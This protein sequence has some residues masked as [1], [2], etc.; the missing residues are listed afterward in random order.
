[1]VAAGFLGL[2]GARRCTVSDRDGG[3]HFAMMRTLFLQAPSFDGFDGGAGARYQMSREVRSF[4]YPTWL[5]QPAALVEGSKL[6]DAPPHRLSFEDVAPEATRRDLVVMHTST[7]SFASDV[8]TAEALKALN[9]DLKIGLI[10]AKV[11]VE[12]EQSLQA[13]SAI[14]F[15]ARNEFDFTIKD[16]AEGR[17]LSRVAGLSWRRADGAIVHNDERA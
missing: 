11:A 5:A 7:P 3:T 8:R 13:S 12:P 17:E 1:M 4:W 6:I 10:G 15:V 9:P 2:G 14:D 16:V